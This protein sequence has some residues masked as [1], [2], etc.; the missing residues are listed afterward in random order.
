MR[1][2][3]WLAVL[4]A[5]L[6]LP[7]DASLVEFTGD[8]AV[9]FFDDANNL[10]AQLAFT[11]ATDTVTV[12]GDV[13]LQDSV[14]QTVTSSTL[15][16]SLHQLEQLIQCDNFLV[17]ADFSG[18]LSGLGLGLFPG[19]FNNLT[20]GQQYAGGYNQYTNLGYWSNVT[21]PLNGTFQAR[22]GVYECA[23]GV[24]LQAIVTRGTTP[25]FV[26]W[27]E[28]GGTG[29][30]MTLWL[31]FVFQALSG[32]VLTFN[33][34]SIAGQNLYTG[35]TVPQT[36]GDPTGKMVVQCLYPA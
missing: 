35:W 20:Y 26:K 33:V 18:P 11:Q 3:L 4:S 16:S 10:Q 24:Q 23:S 19:Q 32:D 29:S 21:I 27:F 31:H 14:T 1:R 6:L 9:Q 5:L 34:Q 8:S 15:Y 2:R 12:Q 25:V 30:C 7:A 28:I 36:V 17:F 13:L 22:W